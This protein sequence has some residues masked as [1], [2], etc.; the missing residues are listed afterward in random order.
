MKAMRLYGGCSEALTQVRKERGESD[1][2]FWFVFLSTYL[3]LSLSLI[4]F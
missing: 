1:G 2:N 3:S 4:S